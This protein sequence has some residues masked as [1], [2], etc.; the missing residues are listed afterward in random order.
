[1]MCYASF[2]PR[3]LEKR[4]K[5][6]RMESPC[7]APLQEWRHSLEFNMEMLTK[8]RQELRGEMENLQAQVDR[9][10]VRLESFT[11]SLRLVEAMEAIFLGEG[12][13]AEETAGSGPG[14]LSVETVVKV[15]GTVD[16][17][18]RASTGKFRH[19]L[20]STLRPSADCARRFAQAAAP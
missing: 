18:G 20:T 9:V 6:K 3:F 13:G 4:R 11:R 19:A 17:A 5:D 10:E 2:A 15:R 8:Q 14:T 7:L 16:R 1:M 12:E